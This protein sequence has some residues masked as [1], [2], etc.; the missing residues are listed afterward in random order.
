[1]PVSMRVLI[2]GGYGTFGGNIARLLA[3]EKGLTLVISGRKRRKAEA[4]CQDYAHKAAQFIPAQ[5]DRSR[6]LKEQ[7]T[8][9]P[10]VIIDATGPFQNFKD[11]TRNIVINY[12]L[13]NG[14]H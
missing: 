1:M 3:D 11:E 13:E 4:F 5:I 6:S 10:D 12:A 7:I 14:V 2:L 9:R 8:S